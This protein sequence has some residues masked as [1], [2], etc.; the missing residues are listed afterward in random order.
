MSVPETIKIVN[1]GIPIAGVFLNQ[2]NSNSSFGG[3]FQLNLNTVIPNYTD[4]KLY[5]IF[6]SGGASTRYQNFQVNFLGSNND[7]KVFCNW[8]DTG[9]NNINGLL[10]SSLQQ[11]P[12]SLSGLNYFFQPDSTYIT[13]T[14]L[15][16]DIL[17]YVYTCSDGALFDLNNPACNLWLTY[18][19]V[20]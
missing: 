12:P 1:S 16:F 19:A 8:A 10:Q 11:F 5:K 18:I 9:G 3:L 6:V 14:E 20:A 7:S 17:R 4:N 15:Q 13:R 2:N